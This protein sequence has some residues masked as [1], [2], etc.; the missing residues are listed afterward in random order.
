MVCCQKLQCQRRFP[1]QT[2]LHPVPFL[3]YQHCIAYCGRT[4]AVQPVLFGVPQG[5]VLGPLLYVLY[6]AELT[7]IVARHGLQLHMYADDCQVYLSTSVE[8]IPQA[9]DGF[10]TCVADVNA[11]LT[12]NR[13]R[14]NASKTVLLW[15]GSSQLLDKVTCNEVLLLGTRVNL[16]LC[17]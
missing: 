3:F 17:S 11:W 14:L 16:R 10:T 4:S 9:V 6:T 2:L 1:V 15:L 12:T 13:L 7:K 5:S 8:H